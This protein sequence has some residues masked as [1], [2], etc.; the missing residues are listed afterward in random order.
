MSNEPQNHFVQALQD[1]RQNDKRK[2]AAEIN[3]AASYIST[4]ASAHKG[5]GTRA[6]ANLTQVA[7]QLRN[8][9][10]QIWTNT[11]SGQSGGSSGSTGSSGASGSSGMTSGSS[12]GISSGSTGGSGIAGGSS[13]ASGSTGGSSG[14]TSGGSS[15]SGISSS[16]QTGGQ[17]GSGQNVDARQ[18][19]QDFAKANVA[20]A[21]FFQSQADQN[22]QQ[23]KQVRAGYQL[24]NAVSAYRAAL[25]WSN[26]NAN[27]Q[28]TT[29]V[30][31]DASFAAAQ[32]LGP[33]RQQE[34]M[35]MRK[36]GT[37]GQSN[38]AR[39]SNQTPQQ[40]SQ[41]LATQ[42]QKLQGQLKQGTQ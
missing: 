27:Q 29:K 38:Q 32:L 41:E 5:A 11:S 39:S 6:D 31:D 17:G 37:S 35:S 36:E 30:I 24:D 25:V 14:S 15:G 9:A 4:L 1:L 34:T 19:A 20:L 40:A 16:G 21:S 26:Q 2:A 18:L 12:G 3:I 7:D 42:I 22:L 13:G 23:G 8:D 10:R 33:S 28:D